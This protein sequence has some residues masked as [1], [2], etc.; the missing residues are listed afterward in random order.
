[1][2]SKDNESRKKGTFSDIRLPVTRKYIH[3]ASR[4]RMLIIGGVAALGFLGYT[5]FD[6]TIRQGEFISNGPLST[7][8]ANFEKDCSS[9]HASSASLGSGGSVTNEKCSVCHEK[10]GD[11]IG[12]YTF[13]ARLPVSCVP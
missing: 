4:T 12:V 11:K 3:P 13:A 6:L 7:N 9:C 5:I 8:H 1:M 2:P 10:F